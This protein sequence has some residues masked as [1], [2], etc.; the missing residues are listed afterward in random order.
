MGQ[1][2]RSAWF[3]C[4]CCISNMTRFLP[5][6]PG[7]I[8]A[9]NKNDLYVNLFVGNTAT[10]TLPAGKVQLVEETGYPWMVRSLLPSI[11]LKQRRSHSISVYLNGRMTNLFRGIS[12]L[13]QTA[14]TKTTGDSPEWQT[15]YV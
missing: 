5:S 3:G 8:Y 14:R 9:Q 10:I 2:Q 12:I 1:H 7:Y 15:S 13:M 11:P 4:A 6:M